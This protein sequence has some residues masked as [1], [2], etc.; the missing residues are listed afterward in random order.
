MHTLH[1]H[2]ERDPSSTNARGIPFPVQSQRTRTRSEVTANP[3]IR[4]SWCIYPKQKRAGATLPP[5]LMPILCYPTAV[6]MASHDT[7]TS[8]ETY[9]FI[10]LFIVLPYSPLSVTR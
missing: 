8:P 4:A 3:Q 9:T 7:Q 6:K 1:P 2:N 10:N 5:N